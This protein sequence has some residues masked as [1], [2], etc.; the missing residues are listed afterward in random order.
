MEN[1]HY[2]VSWVDNR[3]HGAREMFA[4]TMDGT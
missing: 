3:E 2:W 1:D 4:W